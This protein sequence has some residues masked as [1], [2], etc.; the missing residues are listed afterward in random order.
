MRLSRRFA[1]AFLAIALVT[2]LPYDALSQAPDRQGAAHARAKAGKTPAPQPSGSD[3][4]VTVTGS[5]VVAY[6][7]N[8]YPDT[9]HVSLHIECGHWWDLDTDT[10]PVDAGPATTVRL[11]GR[12]WE[13]VRSAWVTHA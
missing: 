5:E 13:N 8:A 3:C 4:Q 7:H 11:A 2:A 10:T 6:C 1:P 9:D 12:C